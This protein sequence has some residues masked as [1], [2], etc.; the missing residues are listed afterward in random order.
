MA[1]ICDATHLIGRIPTERVA[2]ITREA[3]EYVAGYE[4]IFVIPT[5]EAE[6]ALWSILTTA[7]KRMGEECRC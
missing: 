1:R 2:T 4:R 3:F 6:K 5:D 7:L